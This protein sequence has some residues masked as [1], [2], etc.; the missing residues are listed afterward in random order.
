[1]KKR[2]FFEGAALAVAF[3]L[4]GHPLQARQDLVAVRAGVLIDGSGSPPMSNAVILIADGRITDV[5]VDVGIPSGATLIDW[6]EYTVLQG[7]IDSHTHLTGR[8]LGEPGW[9]NAYVRDTP[10]DAA[11]HGVEHARQTV[12][13]GFTTVRDV[14]AGGF[15]D[16]SLRD[17]IDAGRILGPRMIV[18]A[19]ALGI[20]GGHCDVNGFVAD[21]FG[22]EAGIQEGVANGPA[23]ILRAVRYQVKYGADVIK[24]CATGGVMS[25]GNSV[26]V[27]QY[28]SEEMRA[29]VEAS[30]M[31]E[32][33]VA[34][35]A[36]GTVG[37]KVALRAGVNSIEHGSILDDEAIELFL[38]TGA[39]LVPTLMAAE[40]GIAMVEAGVLT[41]E[42]AEKALYIS[43]L[44]YD[45]FGRAAAAGVNVALGTDAGVMA[46]GN[47]GH[48]FTLMVEHGMAPMQ[49]IMAGT[50]NAA[51]LLGWGNRIGTVAVDKLADLVAVEGDPLSDIS[52]LETVSV[53]MMNGRVV[54]DNRD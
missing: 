25:E 3:V 18:A 33:R 7:F 21:L 35:H 34:A 11:L 12:Q 38:E 9:E 48:E 14:G 1:M 39:Y 26:G 15:A 6:S 42:R 45:S 20:T 10:A 49:A 32:R 50:S 43:P 8:V 5:G 23:D 29:I 36:H 41:G 22:Q 44:A 31:V 37:I 24:F 19:H 52:V 46:H 2:R 53:V 27:Q 51:D 40:N 28:S 4:F 47:N 13:A 16:V 54:V 17:A 30:H